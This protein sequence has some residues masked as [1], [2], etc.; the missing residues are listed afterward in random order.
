VDFAIW[1]RETGDG[2]LM[3]ISR[4]AEVRCSAVLLSSGI[5]LPSAV[6]AANDVDDVLV[7]GNRKLKE[8]RAFLVCCG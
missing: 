4:R 2:K 5:G 7:F 3:L 6:D 1:W 8:I